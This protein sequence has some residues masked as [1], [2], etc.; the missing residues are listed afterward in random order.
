M[1]KL[2]LI[3]DD[4]SIFSI[5]CPGESYSVGTITRLNSCTI[6]EKPDRLW[7]FAL[8]VAKSVHKFL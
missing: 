6:K 5:C 7:V 1:I 3:K 4:T 2:R 8:P